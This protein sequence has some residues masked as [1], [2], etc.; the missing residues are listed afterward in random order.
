MSK[1][2][3]ITND[4]WPLASAKQMNNYILCRKMEEN[5]LFNQKFRSLQLERCIHSHGPHL[6]LK[7]AKLFWVV[8][9]HNSCAYHMGL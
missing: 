5:R 4:G 6:E 2:E 8:P 3:K 7:M 1:A 9:H